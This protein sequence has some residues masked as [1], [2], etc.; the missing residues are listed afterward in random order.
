MLFEHSL[1]CELH[2]ESLQTRLSDIYKRYTWGTKVTNILENPT[3]LAEYAAGL[4]I[5]FYA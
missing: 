4:C 5:P 2:S 3:T 1:Q